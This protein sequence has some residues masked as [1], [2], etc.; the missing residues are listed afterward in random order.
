LFVFYCFV[1]TFQSKFVAVKE[2]PTDNL[3]PKEVKEFVA[4]GEI[5]FFWHQ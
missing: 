4:E 3:S 2:L 5:F 1:A